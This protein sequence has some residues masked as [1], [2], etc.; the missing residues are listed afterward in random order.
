MWGTDCSSATPL[1]TANLSPTVGQ[2]IT[3]VGC[4]MSGGVPVANPAYPAWGFTGDPWITGG[5][6]ASNASG[7]EAAAPATNQQ[8]FVF[9]FV[10]G[11][12]NGQPVLSFT[13]GTVGPLNAASVT[14][15]VTGPTVPNVTIDAGWA[16][17]FNITQGPVV[18]GQPAWPAGLALGLGGLGAP[19][20]YTTPLA[21]I[22]LQAAA[23]P[24]SAPAGTYSWV[25]LLNYDTI[26]AITQTG[27]VNLSLTP[28]STFA[29]GPVL[30]TQY[31]YASTYQSSPQ[32][33]PN[34]SAIDGAYLIFCQGWG[35]F[36]RSFS[37]TI[38]LLW[39]PAAGATG[40]SGSA[41][42]IPIP[43]GSVNWQWA[44]DA[45]N[46]LYPTT[47]GWTVSPPSGCTGPSQGSIYQAFA[48]VSAYPSWSVTEASGSKIACP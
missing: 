31:P 22:N 43:L 37:A 11:G 36:A 19:S 27:T 18:N 40:C 47:T 41:C 5:Y 35:E 42:T 16:G 25:Q 48:P 45:I 28:A 39:T 14:F 29:A 38:Y 33:S 12:D 10:D 7:Q 20:G 46:T 2:Q 26:Q 15:N 30:D 3:L 34:D 6:S 17:I 4:L 13:N 21:G 1:T 44:G 32:G 24:P 23:Q 9:Y 8:T